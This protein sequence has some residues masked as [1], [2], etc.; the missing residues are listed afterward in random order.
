MSNEKI[1][2]LAENCPNNP[3]TLKELEFFDFPEDPDQR[4]CWITAL[5]KPAGWQ[6]T[7]YSKICSVHFVNS[8]VLFIVARYVNIYKVGEI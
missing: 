6:P 2:C 5:K 4:K 8:G 3:K 7:E 1:I